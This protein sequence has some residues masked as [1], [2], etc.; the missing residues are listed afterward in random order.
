MAAGENSKLPR[1]RSNPMSHRKSARTS[2]GASAKTE[3][4]ES[5]ASESLNRAAMWLAGTK[6]PTICIASGIVPM[7]MYIPARNPISTLTT[8]NSPENAPVLLMRQVMAYI[9]IE[10]ESEDGTTRIPLETTPWKDTGQPVA[11]R[12]VVQMTR[13]TALMIRP[14]ANVATIHPAATCHGDI[15]VT[16]MSR[17]LPLALS[18]TIG[19]RHPAQ[20]VTGT[21]PRMP[22]STQAST[23]PSIPS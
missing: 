12:Y 4:S 19:C 9:M 7:G 20:V 22:E 11:T 5:A 16:R 18:S 14:T 21:I 1:D 15:G 2:D 8:T 13:V 6:V 17:S 10:A 3:S 23:S